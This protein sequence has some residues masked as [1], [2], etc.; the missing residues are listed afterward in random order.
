VPLSQLGPNA[1]F[2]TS[3]RKEA[4]MAR[5]SIA[6]GVVLAL[7]FVVSSCR[8]IGHIEG[9]EM[10]TVLATESVPFK[11]AIPNSYGR[12]VGVLQS[13]GTNSRAILWFERPDSTITAVWVDYIDGV[14][15]EVL[16]IPR[17]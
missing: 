2:V 11:D 9:S 15:E 10:E 16:L 6:I 14:Y 12:F 5:S 1:R 8:P 4:N 7:S 17:K 3:R 13:P